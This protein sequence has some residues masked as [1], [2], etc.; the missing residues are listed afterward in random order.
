[1]DQAYYPDV[2][3]DAASKASQVA[4][5]VLSLAV[6]AGQVA[7]QRKASRKAR[8]SRQQEAEQRLQRER[9]KALRDEARSY[10]APAHDA[11]WLSRADLLQ[12]ARAWSNAAAWAEDPAAASAMRKSEDHLRKLHPYAMARYDRLRDE[13]SSPLDAMREA[14][15]L[16]ANQP[17]ARPHPGSARQAISPAA[18]GTGTGPWA[19]AGI[20][21]LDRQQAENDYRLAEAER[22]GRLAVSRIQAAAVSERGAELSPD[23]LA[24]VLEAQTS[25]PAEVIERLASARHADHDAWR[26]DQERSADLDRAAA[27]P[28]RRGRHA[29]ADLDHAGE[30]DAAAGTARARAGDERS[31]AQVA[32]ANFPYSAAA[33][34]SAGVRAGIRQP[35]RLSAK[36]RLSEPVRRPRQS[37]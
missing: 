22:A 11:A 26:A 33:G 13:G 24:T 2:P 3:G 20:T 34:I 7:A 14:A 8:L 31:A 4:A 9:E 10:W 5:Q 12:T 30:R 23:E 37:A 19:E 16:F 21:S 1:M 15:P 36:H 6:A 18:P 35:A 25:L 29:A 32:E 17:H 28:A 27:R